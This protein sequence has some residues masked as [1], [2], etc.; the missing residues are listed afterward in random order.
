MIGSADGFSNNVKKE[1]EP[2]LTIPHELR[3][4]LVANPET[5]SGAVRF[6]GTRVP[7]QALIDTLD[8]GQG[9]EEFMEGWPN[10][11]REYAEAV[12]HWE[13]NVARKALGLE[14]AV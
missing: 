3:D 12:I 5:L 7:V 4:I 6:K 10:V 13:Q 8:V 11:P 9:I 1:Y 14:L 2:M